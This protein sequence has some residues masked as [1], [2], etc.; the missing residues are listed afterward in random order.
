MDWEELG[1]IHVCG[2]STSLLK[3]L[4]NAV[5][6]LHVMPGWFNEDCYIICIKRYSEI[7]T[8]FAN[9]VQ[10]PIVLSLFK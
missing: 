10:Q 8:A 1:L 3:K 4:Q 9:N 7:F 5:Y 2:Q 6:H